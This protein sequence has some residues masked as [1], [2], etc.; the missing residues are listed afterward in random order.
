M[1]ATA[2]LTLFR[3]HCSCIR[4][5]EEVFQLKRLNTSGIECRALVL[6]MSVFNALT[7]LIKQ[8]KTFLHA[9]AVTEY[10]EV[11]LH[12]VLQVLTNLCH[13]LATA[14]SIQTFQTGHGHLDVGI[15]C[16]CHTETFF[17][18]FLDLQTGRTAED[19][20]V[21]QRV[22]ANAVSA[23]N[24]YASYLA[25]GEQAINNLILTI[26]VHGQSLTTD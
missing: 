1:G 24:R 10:T 19:H 7:N 6:Q 22:A 11:E 25:T 26:S 16:V 23:V 12:G 5:F 14:G 9:R 20:Q 17:Q 18:H 13:A 8:L 2:F 21:K 3:R 4:H 15:G